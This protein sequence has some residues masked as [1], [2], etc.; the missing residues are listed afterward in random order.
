NRQKVSGVGY[1]EGP[2]AQWEFLLAL[3]LARF[4][5]SVPAFVAHLREE[6]EEHR[7]KQPRAVPSRAKDGVKSTTPPGGSNP[8]RSAAS[9]ATPTPTSPR[10][11]ATQHSPA[12]ASP[13][14]P[15]ASWW[16][17]ERVSDLMGRI[18]PRAKDAMTYIAARAPEVA[19]D[20]VLAHLGLDGRATAAVMK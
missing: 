6:L 11:S 7:R 5:N 12:S 19:F 14:G 13:P 15:D 1:G 9:T 16:T 18:S 8:Q 17:T 2:S 3:A 10:T 20:D 4:H